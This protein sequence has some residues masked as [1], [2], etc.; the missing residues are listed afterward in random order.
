MGFNSVFKG[1]MNTLMHFAG[2]CPWQVQ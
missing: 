1:L 2:V